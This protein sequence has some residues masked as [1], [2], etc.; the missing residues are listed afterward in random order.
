MT[1]AIE[2]IR[3]IFKF[4]LSLH[5]QTIV[6]ENYTTVWIDFTLTAWPQISNGTQYCP[7]I[8]LHFPSMLI[9]DLKYTSQLFHS[10]QNQL[11]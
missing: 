1:L 6:E 7:Q 2:I 3:N 8:F 9:L 4:L 10:L 5:F 11:Q